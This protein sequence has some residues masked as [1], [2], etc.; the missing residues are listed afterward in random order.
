MWI[1][2]DAG[3]LA[4]RGGKLQ[5]ADTNSPERSPTPAGCMTLQ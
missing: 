3:H 2:T 4:A 5:P 1:A